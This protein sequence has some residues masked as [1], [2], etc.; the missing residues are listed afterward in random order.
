V[1]CTRKQFIE[2][3]NLRIRS[4]Q[5]RGAVRCAPRSRGALGGV[6]G[7]GAPQ[8][9]AGAAR[10]GEGDRPVVHCVSGR[11]RPLQRGGIRSKAPLLDVL[12]VLSWGGGRRSC[13]PL[14]TTELSLR[15]RPHWGLCWKLCH[16]RR[17]ETQR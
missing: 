13:G 7:E 14:H 3:N 2:T 10:G 5:E 6:E 17:A 11:Q 4:R 12:I 9:R 8:R 15:H 16:P 1:Y